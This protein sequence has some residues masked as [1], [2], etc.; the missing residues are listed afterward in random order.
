MYTLDTVKRR[1]A[2][3][4][5]FDFKRRTSEVRRADDRPQKT[6]N[7][8]KMEAVANLIDDITNPVSSKSLH[9]PRIVQSRESVKSSLVANVGIDYVLFVAGEG[10]CVFETTYLSA[11]YFHSCVQNY[12]VIYLPGLNYNVCYQLLFYV[13]NISLDSSERFSVATLT[14]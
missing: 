11:L 2:A 10:V 7:S 3:G 8:S 4:N 13:S 5:M 6:K 14:F 9:L 12:L 1:D